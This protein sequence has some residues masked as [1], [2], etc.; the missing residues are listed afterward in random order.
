MRRWSLA[1]P[2]FL[3]RPGVSLRRNLMWRAAPLTALVLMIAIPLSI[4]ACG[5]TTETPRRT[6]PESHDADPVVLRSDPFDPTA[7]EDPPE[8]RVLLAR[9]QDARRIEFERFTNLGGPGDVIKVEARPPD[10]VAVNGI[11]RPGPVEVRGAEFRIADRRY[12]GRLSLDVDPEG[13]IRAILRVPLE[14]YVTGVVAGEVPLSW[15]AA[16]LEAQAVAART[17]AL[18][19]RATRLDQTWDVTDDTR[20]QVFI[21]E[22]KENRWTAGLRAAVGATRELVLSRDHRLANAVYHSTCGGQTVATAEA[23]GATGGDRLA[24][25]RCADCS[26]SPRHRW[27]V[28]ITT[29]EAAHATGT[30]VGG[31]RGLTVTERA[32]SG[33]ALQVRA[34]VAGARSSRTVLGARFRKALGAKLPSTWIVGFERT[35]TGFRVRGRGYGH[36]AGL[37]QWGAAGKAKRGLSSAQILADYYPGFTLVRIEVR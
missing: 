34:D 4:H 23:F 13:G 12:R 21:G 35:R 29:A 9:L 2:R 36:G 19:R 18:H 24:G 11:R 7:F 27:T 3:T 32:S 10:G 22:P 15:P 31:I 37:C 30:P 20:S 28:E 26:G 5:T 17:Y 16:A 8:I 33:R 14:A 6:E 25:V 1:R